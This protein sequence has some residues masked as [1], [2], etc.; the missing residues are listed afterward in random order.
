[1]E[2]VVPAELGA[3]SAD[4]ISSHLTRLRGAQAGKDLSLIV[5][6]AKE[7][8]ESVAKVVLQARAEIDYERNSFRRFVGNQR[9]RAS[10]WWALR[11]FEGA[12]N[13]CAQPPP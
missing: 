9:P 2:V 11:R 1:M 7:L 6:C 3:E 4:A 13:Q 8:V 12:R 5:G 10:R